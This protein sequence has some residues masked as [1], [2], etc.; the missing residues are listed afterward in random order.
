MFCDFLEKK[1]KWIPARRHNPS[2]C[3]SVRRSTDTEFGFGHCCVTIAAR[4]PPY[5]VVAVVAA[6][7][8]GAWVSLTAVPP[9]RLT[10]SEITSDRGGWKAGCS[11]HDTT[12]KTNNEDDRQRSHREALVAGRHFVWATSTGDLWGLTVIFSSAGQVSMY[13]SRLLRWCATR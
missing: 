11:R 2:S 10:L 1:N 5:L 12:T 7:L 3:S 9:K 4:R 8:G 6:E 13:R